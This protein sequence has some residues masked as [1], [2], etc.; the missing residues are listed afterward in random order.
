M[1]SRYN[2]EFR[3]ISKPLVNLTKKKAQ[4]IKVESL[5]EKSNDFFLCSVLTSCD[6]E[7][8]Q[9]RKRK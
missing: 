3:N 5:F 4:H 6:F 2:L 1:K 9:I 7:H 8:K